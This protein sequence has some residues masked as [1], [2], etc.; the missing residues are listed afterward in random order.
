MWL[1]QVSLDWWISRIA[2]APSSHW[3]LDHVSTFS[4]WP[5][6]SWTVRAAEMCL[7]SFPDRCLHT[8]C[9]VLEEVLWRCGWVFKAITDWFTPSLQVWYGSSCRCSQHFN[10]A[11]LYLIGNSRI[12]CPDVWKL[13]GNA[14]MQNYCPFGKQSNFPDPA[15][16][17][18]TFTLTSSAVR[19]NVDSF[20]RDYVDPH[21]ASDLDGETSQRWSREM[22]LWILASMFNFDP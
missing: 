4:L 10:W 19:A 13:V 18:T 15:K 7:L 11:E 14:E 17:G 16:C 9:C 22:E 3:F 20:A 1:S 8:V 12:I 21:V 5:L 2:G 6:W